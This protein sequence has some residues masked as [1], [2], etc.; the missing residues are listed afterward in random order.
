MNRISII[1]ISFLFVTCSTSEIDRYTDVKRQFRNDELHHMIT[2]SLQSWIKDSLFVSRY[3]MTESWIIDSSII[4]DK[5]SVR[6]YS[7]VL[8]KRTS[9]KSSASDALYEIGGAKIEDRWWF[10]IMGTTRILPRNEYKYNKYEPLTFRQMSYLAHKNVF[11]KIIV[12]QEDGTYVASERFFQRMFYDKGLLELHGG[13]V[14]GLEE[15][16]VTNA[17][18][19]YKYKLS[20]KEIAEIKE[21]IAN[22]KA[23]ALPPQSWWDRTFNKKIFDE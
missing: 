8:A 9:Y 18:N 17:K 5:N 7:L 20:E 4:I 16:I 10:F 15:Y 12:K 11:S 2:D 3:I 13:T 22:S 14:K 1:F 21:D 19:Q 6:L 23:P